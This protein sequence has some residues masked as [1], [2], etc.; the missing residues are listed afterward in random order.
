MSTPEEALDFAASA[1]ERLHPGHE[2][3]AAEIERI[4]GLVLNEEDAEELAEAARDLD[5]YATHAQG[6]AAR[7]AKIGA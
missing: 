6:F 7:F 4:R 1:V 5:I 2:E 3:I